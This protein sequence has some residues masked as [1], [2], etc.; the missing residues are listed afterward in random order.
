MRLRLKVFIATA[1]TGALLATAAAPASAA[2]ITCPSGQD[3]AHVGGDWFCQNGGGN[4][5]GAGHHKGTGDKI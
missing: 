2:P 5:S 3:P 1:A 4:P